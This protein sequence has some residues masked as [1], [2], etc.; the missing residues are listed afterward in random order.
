MDLRSDFAF[1][2]I[3]L[4]EPRKELLIAFLNELF[5]GRKIIKDLVYLPQESHGRLLEDR[6]V[7]FDLVCT[8]SDGETFLIEMQRTAQKNFVDRGLFYKT[9]RKT[10]KSLAFGM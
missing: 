4:A 9:C 6:K 8:G 7:I 10:Q 5:R 3:F 1:K 2:R